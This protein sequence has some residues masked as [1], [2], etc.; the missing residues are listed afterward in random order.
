VK[1]VTLSALLADLCL[2]DIIV[3]AAAESAAAAHPGV[4]PPDSVHSLRSGCPS[5][6]DPVYLALK[7]HGPTPSSTGLLLLRLGYRLTL[8]LVA[9]HL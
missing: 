3:A 5:V 1:E 4:V 9:C 7:E 6:A 8:P 2:T